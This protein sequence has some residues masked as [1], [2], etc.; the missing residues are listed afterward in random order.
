M[1]IFA[2]SIV[3]QIRSLIDLVEEKSEPEINV[4]DYDGKLV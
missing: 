1:W 2:A 3:L 4:K